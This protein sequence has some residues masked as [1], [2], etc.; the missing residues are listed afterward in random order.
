[1]SRRPRPCVTLGIR[2][3]TANAGATHCSSQGDGVVALSI[4]VRKINLDVVTTHRADEC[5]GGNR[6][7]VPDAICDDIPWAN[8]SIRG[9]GEGR[10]GLHGDIDINVGRTVVFCRVCDDRVATR[11]G[12]ILRCATATAAN[13]KRLIQLRTSGQ[14]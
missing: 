9:S 3:C 13:T 4:R 1:M 8:Q 2:I 10:A 7:V 12:R 11:H 6:R 5:I 14:Q